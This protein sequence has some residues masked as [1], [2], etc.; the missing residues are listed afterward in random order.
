[1][2]QRETRRKTGNEGAVFHAFTA[3]TSFPLRVYACYATKSCG[4]FVFHTLHYIYCSTPCAAIA[5]AG[6]SSRGKLVQAWTR[7]GGFT[8]SVRFSL[9]VSHYCLCSFH[10]YDVMSLYFT[11]RTSAPSRGFPRV[12]PLNGRHAADGSR[13]LATCVCFEYRL[14]LPRNSEIFR[15]VSM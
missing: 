8:T 9:Q 6:A 2:K 7:P 12:L 15:L 3:R 13:S 5:L 14:L 11:T 4:W 10:I 1:M